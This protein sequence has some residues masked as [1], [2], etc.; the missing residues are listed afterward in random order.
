VDVIRD[1]AYPV[2]PGERSVITIGAYDGLHL[3]HREVLARVNTLAHARG[4]RSVVVTFARHPALVVRPESAPLLL[5]SPDERLELMATTGIDAAIVLPFGPEEAAEEAED[6]VERVFVRALA[7]STVVVGSDF[8]F[9]RGRRGDVGML[10]R[11]GADHDFAVEPIE[12][13]TSAN[14]PVISSTAVRSALTVGNL[15]SAEAMLGRRHRVA[16]VVVT[17][18]QRGRTIGFPTANVAVPSERQI[19]ADGVYAALVSVGEGQPS[20]PAVVN[21]GRRPTFDADPGHSLVEAH[22][23]DA[24]VDL[25][26]QRLVVEFVD[27]LRGEQ[28]FESVDELV[29]Q[30]G[31]DCGRARHLLGV[32]AD[33][34]QP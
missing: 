27:R 17:G 7:V 15:E 16:G 22:L 33:N 13:L 28:R 5:T 9:G 6:F 18:D 4:A 31:A 34:A 11:M 24:E 21:I 25:Y 10:R 26:G 14:G 3:G 2:W 12:L 23:I 1:L 19:P 29:A 30:I 8:H 20:R 32:V